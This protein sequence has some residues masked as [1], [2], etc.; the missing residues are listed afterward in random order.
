MK[1]QVFL[2]IE[3]CE[4]EL[5]EWLLLEYKHAAKIWDSNVIFTNV[6]DETAAKKLKKIGKVIKKNAGEY[7]KDK[8]CIVLDP[9]SKKTLKTQDFQDLYAIIIG[10]ILGCEKPKGRTKK[11]ISDKYG[12]ET[13]NLGKIQLTIDGE[14]FVARAI[15]LG[16]DLEDIE[17]AYE[18]EIKHDEIHSTVLP[19]G[20]PIVNSLPL[21]TPGLIE[22]LSKES[23]N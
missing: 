21:V 3:H 23:S 16:L 17:I 2:I 4:P 22:Y 11:M 14:A 13:R 18:V 12:F 20:Y 7:L 15:L 5:S 6:H 9:Q 1:K 10:G 19:F 8:R